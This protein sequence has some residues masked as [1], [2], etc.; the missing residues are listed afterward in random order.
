[1][2]GTPKPR[3]SPA[4]GY[5]GTPLA[6]KLGIKPAHVVALVGAPG[7]WEVPELPAD[8]V[9][10]R[11]MRSR[12]DVVVA[13]VRRAV[14]LDA[15][16]ATVVPKLGSADSLWVAW[17]R[18]AGGHDSDV[19][20]NLLRELLLPTGLVDVKVAALDQNWSGLRFVRRRELRAPASAR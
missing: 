16:L 6:K 9:V 20:E 12:A 7:G 14:E 19:T 17:P 13:F 10:R 1:M 11:G 4:A 15:V 2:A 18:R 3:T 5:S 8:V